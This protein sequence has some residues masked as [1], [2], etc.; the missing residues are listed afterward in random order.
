ML[1]RPAKAI[2]GTPGSIDAATLFKLPLPM[3][4]E[5]VRLLF[6]MGQSLEQVRARLGLSARQ[7]RALAAEEGTFSRGGEGIGKE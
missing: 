6:E 5:G 7:L 3:Q 1:D 2:F 4:A